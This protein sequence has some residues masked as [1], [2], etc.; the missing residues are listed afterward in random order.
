MPLTSYAIRTFISEK[1]TEVTSS[2]ATDVAIEFPG[3]I[4]WLSR[5]A[6][7]AMLRN[8]VHE[9]SRPFAIQ[10][11]R[12]S[13]AALAEYS[14]AKV[15]LDHF[16]DGGHGQWSPYFR[17]LY[18]FEAAISQLYQAWDL[19]R[20]WTNTSLFESNDGGFFDRLNKIYNCHRHVVATTDQPLWITNGGL[21]CESSQVTFAEIEDALR[22]LCRIA[23]RLTTAK[24]A[25]SE[26]D[27]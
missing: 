10:F 22:R 14:R 17:A 8:H 5:F 9:Q 2:G 18:H 12:R 6:L 16:V 23:E 13:S 19:C 4:E 26:S 24:P 15:E 25:P 3:A 1:V 21:A 27:A 20:K 11:L 7:V